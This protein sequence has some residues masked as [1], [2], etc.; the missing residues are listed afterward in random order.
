MQKKEGWG[1][2][3]YTNFASRLLELLTNAN[4]EFNKFKIG[5]NK[6]ECEEWINIK[7]NEIKSE[8]MKFVLNSSNTELNIKKLEKVKKEFKNKIIDENIKLCFYEEY[9]GQI[10]LRNIDFEVL[11]SIIIDENY[12]QIE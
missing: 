4:I 10:Y 3:N 1:G 9:I 2:G 7:D 8:M 11:R 6:K 5:K 12:L